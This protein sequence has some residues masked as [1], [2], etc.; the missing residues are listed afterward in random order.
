MIQENK[1]KALIVWSFPEFIKHKRTQEWYFLMFATVLGLLLF[2]I[3]TK[4]FLFAI[5]IILFSII[6]ILFDFKKPILIKFQ[7]TEKGIQAS[8]NFY[9]WR[10][11]ENF[12]IIY[13]LPEVKNLYFSFKNFIKPNFIIS[14]EDQNPLKIREILLKYLKEDL[15]QEEESFSDQF[16]RIIKI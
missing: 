6:L 9:Y 5:I 10:E 15:E 4:N 2:S 11:L 13:Q 14:L 8:E 3:F 16:G 7:I 1:G 12:W